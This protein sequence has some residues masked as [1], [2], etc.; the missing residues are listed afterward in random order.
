MCLDEKT[1]CLGWR[2]GMR[3]APL[4]EKQAQRQAGRRL[5][6]AIVQTAGNNCWGSPGQRFGLPRAGSGSGFRLRQRHTRFMGLA[7]VSARS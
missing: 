4:E 3:W 7:V 1:G 2:A 6:C 5:D